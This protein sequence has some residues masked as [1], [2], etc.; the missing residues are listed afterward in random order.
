MCLLTI[1]AMLCVVL[2][3]RVMGCACTGVGKG[4]RSTS[5]LYLYLRDA[6]KEEVNAKSRSRQQ[7]P[8]VCRRINASKVCPCALL[9][10]QLP[11]FKVAH[12]HS[13]ASQPFHLGGAEFPRMLRSALQT[14]LDR[15]SGDQHLMMQVE[16]RAYPSPFSC[17]AS[18]KTN[19]SQ[20]RLHTLHQPSQ[21]R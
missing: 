13:K 6:R 21:E 3:R 17:S 16:Q 18:R 5:C 2:R 1:F 14:K 9:P 12:P 7:T 11:K 10:S 8:T 4:G 20:L 19:S 15:R